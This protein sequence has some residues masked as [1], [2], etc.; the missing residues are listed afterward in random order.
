MKNMWGPTRPSFISQCCNDV[1]NIAQQ[2]ISRASNDV[3]ATSH[4]HASCSDE[5][6]LSRMELADIFTHT[7]L[8]MRETSHLLWDKFENEK[9]RTL[10]FVENL[11]MSQN[12]DMVRPQVRSILSLN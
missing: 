4:D 5:S 6:Y 1:D 10:D 11:S 2:A 9:E 7:L 3:R 8:D 12:G